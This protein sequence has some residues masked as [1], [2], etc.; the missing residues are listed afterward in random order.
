MVKRQTVSHS[1]RSVGM[2]AAV[3]VVMMAESKLKTHVNFETKTKFG[4]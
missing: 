2:F 1:K 3:N 4:L